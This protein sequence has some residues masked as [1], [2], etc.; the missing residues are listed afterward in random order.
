M[1][2]VITLAAV[3]AVLVFGM[4]GDQPPRGQHRARRL[5]PAGV[6]MHLADGGQWMVG[7]G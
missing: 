6:R 5:R 2:E 3:L 1:I 7:A 4:M